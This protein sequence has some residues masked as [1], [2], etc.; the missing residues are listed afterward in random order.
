VM[1]GRLVRLVMVVRLV[2]LVMMGRLVRLGLLVRA[3]CPRTR[4]TSRFLVPIR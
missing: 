3:L 4:T 2:R 1:M